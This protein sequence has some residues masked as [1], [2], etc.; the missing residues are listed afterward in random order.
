[1]GL[2]LV[3]LP[4]LLAGVF[5]QALSPVVF[6]VLTTAIN[7]WYLAS[8]RFP[9]GKRVMGLAVVDAT[10]GAPCTLNQSWTRNTTFGVRP[11]L[12]GV[13]LMFGIKWAELPRGVTLAI[14]VALLALAFYEASRVDKGLPRL[15][16]R[17]A[18]TRVIDT[19]V[20]R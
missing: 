1:V 20:A 7:L 6:A 10:T 13:L 18:G 11:L 16:D 4:A 2:G 15:G 14:D 9:I 17:W 5:L 12:T 3:L 8:D 19:R